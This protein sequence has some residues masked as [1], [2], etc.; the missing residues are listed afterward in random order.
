M[1]K[2]LSIFSVI[3]LFVFLSISV[4]AQQDLATEISTEESNDILDD[5]SK[6]Y[7][8]ASSEIDAGTTPG[9]FG[10][11][12]DEFFDKFGKD[13]DVMA[14][15]FAETKKLLKE[16]K[17]E[18]A[19]VALENF[20]EYSL[21]V[22]QKA[23]PSDRE[24][25]RKN[26]AAINRELASLKGQGNDELVAEIE[27]SARDTLSAME[28]VKVISDACSNL[29][30]LAST[31]DV[32]AQSYFENLCKPSDD[33][34]EWHK[35]YYKDLTQGQQEEVKRFMKEIKQCFKNP[36]NCN[37]AAATDN[38]AFVTQCE[39]ITKAEIDCRKGDETA[40]DISEELGD[41]IFQSL[42]DQPYLREALEDIEKE[43]S[44]ID[45]DRFDNHLPEECREAGATDRKNCMNIMFKLNAPEECVVAL[46]K[47]EI[48]LSNERDARK[49][50]EK[51]MFVA[52]APQECIDAGLTDHKECGKF[53]F[54]ESAPQECIDAG[55]TGESPR[56][57]KKCRELME[58]FRDDENS[59]RGE[60][61]GPRI[62]FDCK[63]IENSEERLKCFDKMASGAQEH[64]ENRGPSKGFPPQCEEAGATDKDSCEKIM[65]QWGENQR[66]DDDEFDDSNDFD[67]S[68]SNQ[69]NRGRGQGRGRGKG[70]FGD[71][72]QSPC[73][74]PE[75][76]A[77]FREQNPDFEEREDDRFSPSKDFDS[78]ED[79]KEFKGSES[80]EDSSNNFESSSDN[81]GSSSSEGGFSGG[82]TG[83]AVAGNN[84]FFNYYFGHF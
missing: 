43:F 23:N 13:S 57:G 17:T 19:K 36:A 16:G 18:D 55:L 75:E 78:S 11:F 25:V 65:R 58:D 6:E 35:K 52:N 72:K 28:L 83:N 37:C 53:M 50:C 2:R 7:S 39:L 31:G 82:I 59:G 84:R 34:S 66:R 60:N 14:E 77:K 8:D 64:F 71:F 21:K 44:D 61:R 12:V 29:I 9:Q 68:D 49:Q 46:E 5:V 33:S 42:E 15:R 10:Y 26:I 67:S 24:A 32:R 30:N 81:S 38:Q 70:N 79:R 48:D 27:N 74:T 1:K 80:L 47:G 63:G 51:V 4:Y 62:N 20:R 45:D 40:C 73:N 76:C 54:K 56:D 22:Q 41:E 3:T 69:D